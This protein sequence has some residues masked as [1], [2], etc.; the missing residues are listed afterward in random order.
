MKKILILI[1][2]LVVLAIVASCNKGNSLTGGVVAN[3]PV[4]QK[5]ET[6]A[7]PPAQLD[8]PEENGVYEVK[9]TDTGF[10]PVQLEISVGD[11]VRWINA[12]ESTRLEKAF[13]VGMR[14]CLE[15]RSET[16][17]YEDTFEWT[18]DQ[19]ETCQVVEGITVNQIGTIVIQ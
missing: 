11:T 6:P 1:S 17:L 8:E 10:D 15:V 13:I 12:R 14:N 16:L 5:V 9:I 18:F 4:P 7:T 19:A 3:E 2:L